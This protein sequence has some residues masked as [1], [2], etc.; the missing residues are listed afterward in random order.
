MNVYNMWIIDI[1]FILYTISY[2]R[3]LYV[4]CMYMETEF[5]E[6][7]HNMYKVHYYCIIIIIKTTID[8][9]CKKKDED[10]LFE[11]EK[12]IQY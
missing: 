4:I 6:Y 1:A 8:D 3:V 9:G 5:T 11:K 2:I 7:Y 10:I 12:K